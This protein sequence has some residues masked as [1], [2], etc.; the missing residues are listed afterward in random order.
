VPTGY[1]GQL[2]YPLTRTGK[3]LDEGSGAEPAE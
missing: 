2:L 1:G 3:K